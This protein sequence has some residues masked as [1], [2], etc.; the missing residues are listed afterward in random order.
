MKKI[1]I[2]LALITGEVAAFFFLG[3]ARNLKIEIPF[4]GWI[5]AI[6][7]PVLSIIGLWVSFL[8]GKKFLF[9]FQAA[10]FFLIGILATLVDLTI[11]N[12]LIQIFQVAT[13][14]YF[15]LFKGISF[16]FATLAKYGGDKFWAFEKK[17][18]RGIGKEFSQF[19]AVTF[20]GL[21]INVGVASF[22]VNALGSQDGL[23][24]ELLANVGGIIAAFV[25]AAWNFFGYKFI[26]FKK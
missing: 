10:K 7:F 1:D 15:S 11:L 3:V 22:I 23:S 17:E 5:L 19:L 2:I 16:L 14:Y 8:I 6:L 18:T 9:I 20:I 24:K 26:V 13:G 25:V 4:L 21:G 12:L